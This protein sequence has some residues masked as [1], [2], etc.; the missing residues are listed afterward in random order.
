M[1]EW[2][3]A[4]RIEHNPPS[5]RN[6]SQ[7]NSLKAGPCKTHGS[8]T[9]HSQKAVEESSYDVRSSQAKLNQNTF[10]NRSASKSLMPVMMFSFVF[11]CYPLRVVSVDH[12]TCRS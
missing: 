2:V 5:R 1:G 10:I 12:I 3:I 9:S 4:V 8:F 7:S 6:R 11:K